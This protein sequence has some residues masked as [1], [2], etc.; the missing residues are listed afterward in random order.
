MGVIF[1]W[2]MRI[3]QFFLEKLN[4][5]REIGGFELYAYCLM[6]NHVHLLIKEG[7]ELGTSI[8]RMTVGYVQLHNNKYG[9]TGHLSYRNMLEIKI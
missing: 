7:K 4:K 5:A 2:M 3:D 1:F 8:K 9:R 6:D